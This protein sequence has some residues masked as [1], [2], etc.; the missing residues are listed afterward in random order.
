MWH[1]WE[2]TGKCIGLWWEIQKGKK[3]FEE[4]DI[5]G[6]ISEWILRQTGWRSAE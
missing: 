4:L 6:R 2:R 1:A 5:D 3:H